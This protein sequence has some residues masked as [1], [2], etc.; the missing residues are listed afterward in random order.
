MAM[1]RQTKDVSD[2]NNATGL[3]F[4]QN[5]LIESGINAGNT[6][7]E[8]SGWLHWDFE[9]VLLA[10]NLST[11][12]TAAAYPYNVALQ[13]GAAGFTPIVPTRANFANS[14]FI[15]LEERPAATFDAF[16]W[17]GTA[18]LISVPS[19]NFKLEWIGELLL[20]ANSDLYLTTYAAHQ[21]TP[22]LQ[23]QQA[24]TITLYFE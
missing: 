24:G 1:T 4:G 19:I 17:S 7:T 22:Q 18:K 10:T 15:Y 6:I 14:A 12:T 9:T 21:G 2:G 11:W 13:V 5:Y 8:I 20:S 23:F 3:S 16:Q